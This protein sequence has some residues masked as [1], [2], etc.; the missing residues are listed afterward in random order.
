MAGR[1]SVFSHP[2]IIRLLGESFVPVADN[3]GYTQT[4]QDAKGEFFRL[5]AEQGH[6]GGRT[7]P[8]ATRQ[9]LYT[10]TVAGEL[11]ASINTRDADQVL[12][13]LKTGLDKWGQRPVSSS[14]PD[15][16]AT[17][18]PDPRL[19]WSYPEGGLV[20]KV[21][22]RDL[23]RESG[24]P[25]PRNNIDFAWFTRD[26]ARSL[27]P[28]SPLPGR[29]Y[30]V[31][32]FFAKRIARCHFID[33]VRGQSPRWREEDIQN[34]DLTFTVEKVA[35]GQVHFRLEGQ[36]KNEA[37]P[38]FDVNPF[39]GQAVDKPRG[40]DLKLLGYLR[41][42]LEQETFDAFDAVAAGP[43]WG[44]T[45]YNARFEDM[46]PAPIGFALEIASGDPIERIPPAAI[47]PSYFA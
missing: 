18:Q 12:G 21:T 44:A 10:C 15:I 31:P 46:G 47:G 41:F 24:E 23:P 36:V 3:C 5:V 11:L 39:N 37:P 28:A 20:L 16:P 38:T 30:P 4:Q 43:R 8:T 45:T 17:Y 34:V 9:G 2:E 26:E 27:I 22:V 40:M 32:P 29:S 7:K 13:M 35:P 33:T 19:N 42:N 25:D 6:Y 14:P 1:A